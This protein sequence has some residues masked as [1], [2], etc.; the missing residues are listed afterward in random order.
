MSDYASV[1]CQ[2]KGDSIHP[3]WFSDIREEQPVSLIDT[4]EVFFLDPCNPF[5]GVSSL[6]PFP[7]AFENAV[8]NIGKDFL[9]DHVAIVVRPSLNH[10]IQ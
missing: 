10:W 1:R 2:F 8:I 9:G 4:D 3:F 5:V 7:Y 6:R